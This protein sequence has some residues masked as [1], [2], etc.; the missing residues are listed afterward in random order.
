[1]ATAFS[2][3]KWAKE[4]Y[5]SPARYKCLYGGRASG[6][7]WT[8]AHILVLYAAQ[9]PLTIMC[10]REILGTIHVSAKRALET[11]IHN[12]GLNGRFRVY[13]NVIR[14]VNGS[15]FLFAG[16]EHNRH[17][18]RGW[19]DIDIVWVEEAQRISIETARVLI[20]TIRK[21][22]SQL[23]F[24]WNPLNRTDW[25][26]ERFILNS[27][28][29]DMTR[30]INW[31]DN[32]WLPH[33]ANLERLDDL[34][35]HPEIYPHIWEGE[36]DDSG[37]DTRRI[38]TYQHVSDCVE[39]YRKMDA[40]EYGEK[41]DDIGIIDAGFDVADANYNAMAIRQ[42]PILYH[43]ER[44]RSNIMAE[45]AKYVDELA[46]EWEV[47][48]VYYDVAGLGAGIRSYFAENENRGYATRPVLFGGRVKGQRTIYSWRVTNA[49]FF[50]QRKEQLAWALRLRAEKTKQLLNNEDVNPMDCLFISPDIPDLEIYLS[51]MTQPTWYEGSTSRVVLEKMQ[52]GERSPD[53]FDA[54]TLAFSHDS[55]YG[56]KAR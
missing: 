29:D 9:R 39:A 13:R 35:I 55:E 1:M 11:A 42:G 6:K 12:L 19:E 7:T 46:N 34:R 21:S 2:L 40:G 48:R 33:E 14:G 5:E 15:R 31:E 53:M 20:P 30:K 4:F 16:L 44:W 38:L 32:P 28:S 51:E 22:G 3:P 26:W 8:V 23:W 25:V 24:T 52:P 37:L 18:I 45:T 10:A 36:P 50:M 54:T 49:Q 17:S 27:R 43:V 47:E 56:L 41:P